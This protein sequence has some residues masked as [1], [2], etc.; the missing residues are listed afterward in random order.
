MRLCVVLPCFFPGTDFPTALRRV[1]ALGYDA[2]ELWDWQYL[3][4]KEAKEALAETGVELLSLC[5]TDFRL[6]EPACRPQVL[7][8]IRRSCEAAVALGA[9]KL[10]TQVGQATDAPREEQHAAIV[11]TLR[12]AAPILA[13]Y[14]VTLMIEP[15]NSLVDHKGYYLTSSAEA[16]AMIEEVDS[17]FVKV[18]F[19]LYHQQITEGT[20]IPTV[21][22]NLPAVAHLHAAGHPGRHEPWTGETDYGVVFRALDEAGY[23]GAV[24]LEYFPLL[25]PE[26]SLRRARERYR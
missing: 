26:E 19:D 22:Q 11:E 12:Q 5:T 25:D 24:G 14:G 21:K 18:I 3:D 1:A 15:L 16:F 6:N 7:E 13:S 23:A 2:V 17:P 10:I 8:G 20:L 9:G 4:L